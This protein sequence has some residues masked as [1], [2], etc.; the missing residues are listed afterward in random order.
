MKV[1]LVQQ[2]FAQ[3]L[4]TDTWSHELELGS[5]QQCFAHM[6]GFLNQI[7]KLLLLLLLPISLSLAHHSID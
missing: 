6:F 7:K 5:M 3:N 1:A 2:D 4:H